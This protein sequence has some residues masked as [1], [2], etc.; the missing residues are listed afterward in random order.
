MHLLSL[1]CRFSVI[2][3]LLLSRNVVL[4]CMNIVVLISYIQNFSILIERLP[5]LPY[6]SLSVRLLRGPHVLNIWL[7][8][9]SVNK[10]SV[11]S[12]LY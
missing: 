8:V 11:P 6:L 4:L 12:P 5:V 9:I 1:V 7:V 3:R 2:T 10:L